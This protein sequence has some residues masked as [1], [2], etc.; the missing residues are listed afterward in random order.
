MD[1]ITDYIVINR[2]QYGKRPCR[3][4]FKDYP[5]GPRKCLAIPHW[6]DPNIIDNT[7]S[8][9]RL[10]RYNSKVIVPKCETRIVKL[11]VDTDTSVEENTPWQYSQ[12][13]NIPYTVKFSTE[14]TYWPIQG[15]PTDVLEIIEETFP[16]TS[17]TVYCT[18]AKPKQW[19]TTLFRPRK[20]GSILKIRFDPLVDNLPKDCYKRV[21]P[22]YIRGRASREKEIERQNRIR[23]QGYRRLSTF[24][25]LLQQDYIQ[26]HIYLEEED[27][28]EVK[29]G[30][31]RFIDLEYIDDSELVENPEDLELLEIDI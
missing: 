30:K 3:A 9:K 24:A 25:F 1:I 12:E 29:P 26:S 22:R 27:G 11:P 2:K 28:E 17:E 19:D 16:D 10:K 18:G 14:D 7:I 13:I 4:Y 6:V 20:S 21:D 23:E 8:Y 5:K 15:T 31:R